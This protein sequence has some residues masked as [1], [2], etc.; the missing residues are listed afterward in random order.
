M[1]VLGKHIR[2]ITADDLQAL[3]DN[4]VAESQ[5]LEYKL[6][7]PGNSDGEK[8]EFLADVSSLANTLG[9]VVVYGV[10][11]ED[12]VPK[13]VEGVSIADLDAEKLRLENILRDGL[14]PRLFSVELRGLDCNEKTVLVL[15]VNRSLLAPHIVWFQRDGKFHRRNSVGKYQMDV[16]EIRQ[17]FLE[18]ESYVERARTFRNKRV[19]FL[20]SLISPSMPS[21]YLLHIIPLG[22]AKNSVDFSEKQEFLRTYKNPVRHNGWTSRPN[23]DGFLVYHYVTPDFKSHI[24]YLRDGSVEVFY[25]PFVDSNADDKHS[26]RG[27]LFE[28]ITVKYVDAM[29]KLLNSSFNIEPPVAILCTILGTEN[30]SINASSNFF[31][32]SVNQIDRRD[33]YLPEIIVD[34]LVVESVPTLLRPMFDIFWQSAGWPRSPM[35][36]KDGNWSA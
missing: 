11:E 24:Q 36:D 27:I 35:F 31:D 3:I 15:G 22:T 29:L 21:A 18:A 16:H 5:T 34:N 33:L 17:A 19:R 28:K 10:A 23:L 8:K 26:I 4:G 12:G 7:L 1:R 25:S 13:S 14:A 30:V 6:K 2:D 9:G 32:P 20:R